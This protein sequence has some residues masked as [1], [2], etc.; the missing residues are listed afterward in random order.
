MMGR[1]C[2][3]SGIQARGRIGRIDDL[4]VDG[5]EFGPCVGYRIVNLG[6]DAGILHS[7]RAIWLFRIGAAG[8][9]RARRRI[10]PSPPAIK[11]V[12]SMSTCEAN[13]KWGQFESGNA[14]QTP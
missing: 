3:A 9:E 1:W 2:F 13:S 6:V 5:Q 7:C 14:V 8:A 11:T 4:P 12:P 10:G